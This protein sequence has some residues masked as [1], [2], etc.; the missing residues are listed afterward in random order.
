MAA[1]LSASYRTFRM[2]RRLHNAGRTLP[3][4]RRVRCLDATSAHET[5]S[6]GRNLEGGEFSPKRPLQFCCAHVYT[7]TAMTNV[8]QTTCVSLCRKGGSLCTNR[9]RSEGSLSAARCAAGICRTDSCFSAGS[10]TCLVGESQSSRTG[11]AP[12]VV[13]KE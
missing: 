11:F 7:R 13:K 3:Q 9:R 5:G 2:A 10:G 12:C 6:Q 1:S 4:L 8:A